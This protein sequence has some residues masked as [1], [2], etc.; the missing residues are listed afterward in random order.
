MREEKGGKRNTQ[1]AW[2]RLFLSKVFCVRSVPSVV[3]LFCD[4]ESRMT[5]QQGRP[6][7]FVP[8]LMQFTICDAE[9]AMRID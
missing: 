4:R 8:R 9:Y 3:K 7:L 2:I 5:P 1:D 6:S